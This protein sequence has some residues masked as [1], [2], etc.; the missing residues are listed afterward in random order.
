MVT[1]SLRKWM[2]L[3]SIPAPALAVFPITSNFNSGITPEQ[4]GHSEYSSRKFRQGFLREFLKNPTGWGFPEAFRQGISAG[5]LDG[6]PG[7]N[8]RRTPVGIPEQILGENPGRISGNTPGGVFGGI[9]EG[10]Y[11]EVF[12]EELLEEFLEESLGETL[13]NFL[14]KFLKELLEKLL[15]KFLK[16]SMREFPG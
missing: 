6:I 9:L 1:R 14:E 7:S 13:R 3:G 16:K 2:V 4:G 10:V 12:R 8:L 5:I 15:W 11:V